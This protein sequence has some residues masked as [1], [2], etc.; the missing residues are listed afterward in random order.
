MPAF[1][2]AAALVRGLVLAV[3]DEVEHAADPEPLEHLH[4]ADV[5]R[6]GAHE[7]AVA[8]VGET[9]GSKPLGHGIMMTGDGGRPSSD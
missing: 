8:H 4:V 5:E 9:V 3:L 7:Q 6:K 2:S 1:A